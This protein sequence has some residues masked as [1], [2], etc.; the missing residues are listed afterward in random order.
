MRGLAALLALLALP[1]GQDSKEERGRYRLSVFGREAGREE[2]RLER[3]DTGRTV[4]FSTVRF[5]V[6]IAGKK[7]GFVVDAALTMDPAY[8]PVL[9]AGYHKAGLDE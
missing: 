3:F 6:E 1:A 2:F 7:S 9:Y 8:A 4:L 5:E